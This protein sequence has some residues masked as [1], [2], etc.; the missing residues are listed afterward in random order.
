MPPIS[1]SPRCREGALPEE[2]I[3]VVY[4]PVA[5]VGDITGY[6]ETLIYTAADGR[7][8]FASAYASETHPQGNAAADLVRASAAVHDGAA[9]PYGV[10]RTEAGDAAGLDILGRPGHPLQSETV[11]HGANLSLQWSRVKEAYA[12]IG[13]AGITYSPLTQNSNSTA[14]TAMATAGIRPPTDN[15]MLGHHWVPASDNI[16]P[17][18]ALAYASSVGSSPQAE[19][20]TY[21]PWQATARRV[22]NQTARTQ[23]PTFRR[24][25]YVMFNCLEISDAQ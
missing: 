11:A 15:G 4:K 3:Q 13:A 14:S 2:T 12:E 10:L 25:A 8:E 22:P 1:T 17:I 5:S 18:P 16:L 21:D 6:H 20:P 7:R 23:H 24:D 19:A 9:S